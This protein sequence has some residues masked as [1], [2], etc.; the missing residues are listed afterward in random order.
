MDELNRLIHEL[1]E[2]LGMTNEQKTIRVRIA[3]AVNADG[4]YGTDGYSKADGSHQDDDD[5]EKW[6]LR[7]CRGDG[8]K[9]VHFI[10]ADIPL[11]VATTIEGKVTT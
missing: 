6:A 8:R 1:R 10:E 7:D 3:V 2:E 5:M 11:P 9:V 4:H